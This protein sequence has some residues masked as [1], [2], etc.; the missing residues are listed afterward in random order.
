MRSLPQPPLLLITDR[1]QASRPLD[2]VVAAA[3]EGGIRWIS[4]REKD[5]DPEARLDLLRRLQPLTHAAS[6]LLM[7]HEDLD[8]ATRLHLD[9]VHLPEA[10]DAAR[11]RRLLPEALIGQSWHGEPDAA[12][13]RDPAL[14]YLSLSPIFLTESKPGYGPALGPDGLERAAMLTTKPLIALGGVDAERIVPCRA[15]G[16]AGVAVMGEVMRAADPCRAAAELVARFA[17]SQS[18]R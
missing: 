12:M 5:L 2:W 10:G 11:A 16:A 1:R 15:S 3:L 8:A 9:G 14:D 18:R 7:V 6:A 17:A 13:L 4:L